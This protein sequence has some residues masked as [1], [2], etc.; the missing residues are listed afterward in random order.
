VNRQAFSTWLP[1]ILWGA[2]IAMESKYGSAANTGWLLQ[3]LSAWLFGSLD[4]AHFKLIHHILR[5]GGHFFGYGIFG[6]LCFRAYMRTFTSSSILTWALMA[7]T[8]TVFIASLDEWHQ[9]FSPGRAGR[10]EDVA[11]DTAGALVFVSLA[12]VVAAYRRKIFIT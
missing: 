3:K 9:S 11:L 2:I 8:S 6:Y 1:L 4:P 12:A 5:K 10:I 7:V